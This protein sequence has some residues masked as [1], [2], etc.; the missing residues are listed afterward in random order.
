M[1]STDQEI[2]APSPG[3]G[4]GERDGRAVLEVD[5][6]VV[7]A[8][9]GG[10]AAA[11]TLG[12]AGYR[13]ALIDRDLV[14]PPKF[15][16]EK[17]G[18]EQAEAFER[19]DLMKGIAA[20]A[21]PFSHVP[22]IRHGKILDVAATPYYALRYEA[23]VGAVRDQVP[24]GVSFVVG[25]VSDLQTG[26]HRQRVILADDGGVIEARLL[27]IAT[28]IADALPEK[29]GIS[30]RIS[31]EKHSVTL[32]FDLR[33]AGPESLRRPALTY[34]GEGPAN[35]IDYLSLFPLDDVIR[36]NLFTFVDHRDPWLRDFRRDP[37]AALLRSFPALTSF[38][39]DFELCSPVQMWVMNLR[40]AE[41]LEQDGVVVL[42]D[43]YRTSCPAAGIG[44]SR[45]L[46][47]VERLC[48]VHAPAWLATPGMGRDKIVG[49]Y[50][51]PAKRYSDD[52]ALKL[53]L[54]RRSLTIDRSLY[55]RVRRN[56]HFLHRSLA[57]R[58]ARMASA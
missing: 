18:G 29:L 7:G 45:L 36:A 46:T 32:G 55:W 30:P 22:N 20:S 16:V 52:R 6:A 21:T 17:F 5:V 33:S 57:G 26:P 38:L 31:F 24:E 40:A 15:R 43:A 56:E 53:S 3:H 13:V 44:V 39:G 37:K 27:V 47:E 14:C 34:Y 28:G 11:V 19:L 8:G 49:Y 42:G 2:L 25:E 12:R 50:R 1:L 35:A 54:D 10:S 58:L 23:L 51:D 9:L 41:N 4:P 48:C